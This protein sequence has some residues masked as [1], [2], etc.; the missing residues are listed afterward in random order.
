MQY[1]KCTGGQPSSTAIRTFIISKQLVWVY[2]VS[3]VS[4]DYSGHY[5]P[6]SFLFPYNIN[7]T[8]ATIG[9][10][11]VLGQIQFCSFDGRCKTCLDTK[12]VLYQG[13]FCS[14]TPGSRHILQNGVW[15]IY[16]DWNLLPKIIP[17]IP[18]NFIHKLY[19]NTFFQQNT[20][21]TFRSHT[22]DVKDVHDEL[23]PW[24][25]MSPNSIEYFFF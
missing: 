23:M 9:L 13:R 18:W 16:V 8:P 22:C 20:L 24:Y 14:L 15:T 4:H 3:Y 12:P 25:T 21:Q 10:Y 7:H 6:L 2:I 11:T 1:A 5:R 19:N 17:R